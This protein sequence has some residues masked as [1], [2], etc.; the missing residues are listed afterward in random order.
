V[1]DSRETFSIADASERSGLTP[2]K[3]RYL[4]ERGDI[5]PDYITIGST[6]QR[7]YSAELVERL[8]KI[9]RYREKGF[10]LD[11]AVSRASEK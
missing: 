8:A 3:I 1:E 10:K 7:R 5:S 11:A 2:R 9:F 4:E 6:R